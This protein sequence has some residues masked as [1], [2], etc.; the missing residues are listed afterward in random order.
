MYMYLLALKK[1]IY[2]QSLFSRDRLCYYSKL[3]LTL[4]L[5]SA[6]QTNLQRAGCGLPRSSPPECL[7]EKTKSRGPKKAPAGKDEGISG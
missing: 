4:N 6:P 2:T 3:V 1:D 5:I 7:R